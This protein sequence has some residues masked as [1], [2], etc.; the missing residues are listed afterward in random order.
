MVFSARSDGAE[1]LLLGLPH[2]YGDMAIPQYDNGMIDQVNDVLR[3]L[4]P[5]CGCRFVDA[6]AGVGPGD[7]RDGLHPN[8][9]GYAK[10]QK[11]IEAALWTKP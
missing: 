10:M 6:F 9:V 4:C 7:T 5:L 3:S 8:I 2:M 11:A 1:V